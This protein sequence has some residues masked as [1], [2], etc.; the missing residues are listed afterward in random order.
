MMKRNI[1]AIADKKYDLVIVGGGIFGIC[2][3]WDA[4][5]RGLSVALVEQGDFAHATSANHLKMVH[6]GIRYLQHADLYRIRESS[7]ERSSFLRVAPHLVRP[8]PIA[9]P[10]YGHGMQGKE[11][12]RAGLMLYDLMTCDRNRGIRDPKRHVPP[13]RIIS[14]QECLEMFPNLEIDGF[15]GAA[16][17]HDGQMY[18][19]PRLALS[20]LKSAVEAGADAVNYLEATGFIRDGNRIIG[21][22]AQDKL[23]QEDLEI[24]GRVVLN[25]TGPWAKWLL[26]LQMGLQLDPEPFFSR[27]ACFVVGRRL[28]GDHALAVLGQTKDPDAVLSRGKRHLFLA[29]WRDYTLIGV[30]HVV[31]QGKPDE[32]TVTAEDLQSFIDEINASYPSLELTLKDVSMWNAGLTLFGENKPGAIDLSY[33]KRSRVIDHAKKHGL[34][35]LVTLIGVRFTTA[36]GVGTRA[37]DLVFKKLGRRSPK[38]KLEVTP[39]YGGQIDNFD[40]F[41]S[42]A[43]QLHPVLSAGVMT[44]L[45]HNYGSSY[46][47]VLKHIDEDPTLAETL[48]T[49]KVI[50]AE[51][52]HAVREE[53]AHKLGDVVFRRTDLGTGGHPGATAL[54]GCAELVAAELGWSKERIQQE[55]AEVEARFPNFET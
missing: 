37:I 11:A 4:T 12:M 54:Q 7:R 46:P 51:V 15:T 9:I 49:S 44:A 22:K 3:A 1:S 45:A 47:E 53:M 36:G 17:F 40:E 32:F 21:I 27:D 48:G 39:V 14:R 2:A 16:V 28:I 24:R 8:L 26:K 13:G 29:P 23:A 25:A 10:T 31:F 41:L 52:I 50:K 33:G 34:E 5:L 35:G 18:N 55:L 6:G 19:P 42:Q 38:S 30:W 43:K 20:F